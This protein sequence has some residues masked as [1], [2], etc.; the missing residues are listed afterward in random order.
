MYTDNNPLTY[1]LSTAKLDATGQRRVAE[2]AN[3]DFSIHFTLKDNEMGEL[4]SIPLNVIKAVCHSIVASPTLIGSLCINQQHAENILNV[5]SVSLVE[6]K[7]EI[8]DKQWND[9]TLNPFILHFRDGI[10]L[11]RK[12]D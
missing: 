6:S 9:P 3:Y 4:K 11:H 8:K 10:D 12:Q 1:I 5:S 7:D 2:L